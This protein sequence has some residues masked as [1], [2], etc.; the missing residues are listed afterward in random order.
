MEIFKLFL[1][2]ILIL[3]INKITVKIDYYKFFKRN[4]DKEIFFFNIA[5]SFVLGYLV[6]KVLEELYYLTTSII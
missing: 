4:S 6:Y 5:I 1:L 3:L 2:S